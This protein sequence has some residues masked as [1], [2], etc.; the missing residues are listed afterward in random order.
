MEKLPIRKADHFN[1]LFVPEDHRKVHRIRLSVRQIYALA[2][3][4]VLFV[5]FSFFSLA[6][7]LHYHHLHQK[8][9]QEKEKNLAFARERVILLEK[10]KNLETVVKSAQDYANRLASL[11]GTER[12]DLRVGVGSAG[13]ESELRVA[14]LGP[15]VRWEDLSDRVEGLQDRSRSVELRIKE[16]VRVQ[17]DRLLYQASRPSIWPVK[18]WV[19]SDFGYRRSPMSG[20]REFHSGLDIAA[21]WGTTVSAPS[22]GLVVYAGQKGALGRSVIIDHGYGIRSYFGHA[23]SLHVSHGEVVKR[24]TK[25]AKVGNSGHSTGSHLHYEIHVDG[26]PIDPM[27]YILQ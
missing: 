23:S 10:V 18:G 13:R 26:V 6:G 11:V 25:I 21:Q 2:V 5:G 19:T 20:R 7:F 15:T 27:Q 14:S 17:E 3:F 16:L 22:A 4:L 12:P 24:G 8:F 1:F 9:E